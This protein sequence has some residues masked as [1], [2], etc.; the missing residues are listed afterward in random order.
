MELEI[1]RMYKAEIGKK[2]AQN[3]NGEDETRTI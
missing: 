1:K 3:H 2:G